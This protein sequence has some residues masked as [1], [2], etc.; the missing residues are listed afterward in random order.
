M[1]CLTD[2]FSNINQMRNPTGEGRHGHGSEQL[3]CITETKNSRSKEST[4]VQ[5]KPWESEL[6]I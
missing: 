2:E 5:M 1:L 4:L 6:G 3:L